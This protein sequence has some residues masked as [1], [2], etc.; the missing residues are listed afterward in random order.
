VNHGA[1]ADGADAQ[2]GFAESSIFHARKICQ[3]YDLTQ[4][5]RKLCEIGI[6]ASNDPKPRDPNDIDNP[7]AIPYILLAASLSGRNSAVECQLP[8]LDVTG[9]IPV[10]RSNFPALIRRKC[11]VSFLRRKLLVVFK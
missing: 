7:P 5:P 1:E 4:A 10:A 2:A 6:A 3:L 11:L 8:K 9:S